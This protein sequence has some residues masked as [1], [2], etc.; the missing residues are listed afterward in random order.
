MSHTTTFLGGGQKI[1]VCD[2][3]VQGGRE[4]NNLE[5]W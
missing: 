1:N 4:A 5:M 2:F 3:F